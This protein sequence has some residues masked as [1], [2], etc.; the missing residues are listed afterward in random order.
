MKYRNGDAVLY[1]GEEAIVFC[2]EAING[3]VF[4]GFTDSSEDD[5]YP[6]CSPDDSNL[7]PD[8]TRNFKPFGL[9][10]TAMQEA[11]KDGFN[12]SNCEIYGNSWE[13]WNTPSWSISATYRLTTS[14]TPKEVTM[15]EVCEKFGCEVV[16]AKEGK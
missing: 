9:C 8:P 7:K 14:K 10:G 3:K 12:G 11:L 13:T 5:C 15:K 4:F 2:E 16:V 1:S 6:Y